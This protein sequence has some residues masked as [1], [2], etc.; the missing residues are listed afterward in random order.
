MASTSAS[1][2]VRVKDTLDQ[3]AW[4]RFVEIYAPFLLTWG[5]GRG[6]SEADA[7]DLVQD[8]LE[9]LSRELPSFDYD[10]S[11]SFRAWL[12]AITDRRAKNFFRD[13]SRRPSA[14]IDSDIAEAAIVE[15]ESDLYEEQEYRK[16]IIQQVFA[17][18]RNEFSDDV[19]KA[20]LKQ[21][22]EGQSVTDVA[23]ELGLSI[24]QVYLAKS[25]VLRRI[26]QEAAGLLD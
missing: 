17:L 6:L 21:T 25:R 5:L 1:L 9:V 12:K 7:S 18:V 3:E 24:N 19:W 26:R 23:L 13:Q 2:L 8:V 20:F 11:R 22:V 14:G 16:A 10:G 15:S 4:N